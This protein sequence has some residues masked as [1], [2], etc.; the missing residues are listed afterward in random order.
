L[1]RRAVASRSTVR[2]IAAMIAGQVPDRRD[3]E[4]GIPVENQT[5]T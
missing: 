2:A 3:A 5:A 1:N 4:R